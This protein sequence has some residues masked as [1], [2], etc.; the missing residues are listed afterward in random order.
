MALAE[1]LESNAVSPF[2]LFWYFKAFEKNI[3]RK[4]TETMLNDQITES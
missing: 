2:Y 1:I 3:P 4:W